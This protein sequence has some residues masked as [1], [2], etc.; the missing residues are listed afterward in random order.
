[1]LQILAKTLENVLKEEEQKEREDHMR[2]LVSVE[3]CVCF[4]LFRIQCPSLFHK[5]F[6]LC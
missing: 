4:I 6:P 1:M 2:T 3:Y 5:T